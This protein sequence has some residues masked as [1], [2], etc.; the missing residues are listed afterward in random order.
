[1]STVILINPFEIP[2]GSVDEFFAEWEKVTAYMRQQPGFISIKLQRSITQG[3]RFSFVNISEWTSTHAF[4]KAIENAEFRGLAKTAP[5]E[6]TQFPALYE[7][8]RE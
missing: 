6:F 4:Q 7:V 3:A 8:V 1:M 5:E 2:S